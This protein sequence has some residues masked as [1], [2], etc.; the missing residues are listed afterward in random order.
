MESKIEQLATR[1]KGIVTRAE[2]LDAGVSSDE[3]RHR[4]E[5]G[6]L[7][8]QY[9]GVYRVGHRAP[10]F[11]SSYM[12]AVKARGEGALLSGMAAV[13]LLSLIRGTPPQPEVTA[14]TQRLGARHSPSICRNDATTWRGIPVTTVP[15]TLIDVAARLTEDE[16]ARI[17]HEA[18]VLHRVT[19]AMVERLL[20]PNAKGAAKLRAVMRG[21]AKVLLSKLERRF[22]QR[23]KDAGLPLPETNRPVGGRRVDCHW[24]EH[25]LTVELQSYGFHNSRYSWEQDQRRQREAYARGDQFRSYT[26][27]DVFEEP[28]QMMRELRQLLP[29]R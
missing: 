11:E 10:N 29:N 26:W 8:T 14:P 7:L 23:L 20:N 16:L 15:R 5:I 9:R 2:L 18:G 13:Y 27:H 28:V 21:D 19:P 1:A 22:Q 6:V 12:A 25:K 4:L 17:C 3:I 24:P